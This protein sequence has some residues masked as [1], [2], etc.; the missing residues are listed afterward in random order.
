MSSTEKLRVRLVQGD[1]RW[2]DPSGNRE[3]YAG[4]IGDARGCDLVVLPETFT[5]GFSNEAL[6]N[7]ESMQG[8]TA[9]WMCRLAA[10]SGAVICGSIQCRVGDDVF[11][12]MLWAQPNGELKHYDKV[13]LFRMAN[14]HERYGAGKVS[15]IFELKGWRVRPLVCY[16]LRFPAFIRNRF[17]RQRPGDLDYDLLLFVANW[18][19]PRSTAWRTLLRARAIENLCYSI[20]VNRC[21]IDGNQVAYRGDSAAIDF[22]G[23]ALLDVGNQEQVADVHLDLESLRSFRQRFPAH[24]DADDFELSPKT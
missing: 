19:A 21:G 18:P 11:N 23:E 6:D 5:S 7:A 14:E 9:Q 20:G 22:L 16:D 2:H 1:T 17:D 24:Q 4:L 12:R 8:E 15:P 13:H 10:D 3:Y